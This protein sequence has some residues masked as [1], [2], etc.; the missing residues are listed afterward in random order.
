MKNAIERAL[1]NPSF[2]TSLLRR[3]SSRQTTFSAPL[4]RNIIHISIE[5]AKKKYD[6]LT[7]NIAQID[8]VVLA[9]DN[10]FDIVLPDA[11]IDPETPIKH[12]C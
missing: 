2:A 1:S 12:F 8:L 11:P 7:K 9:D 5:P 6:S 10:G 3:R 4:Q